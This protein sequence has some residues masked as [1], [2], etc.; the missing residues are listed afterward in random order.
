MQGARA[1]SC[2]NAAEKARTCDACAL[3]W[4]VPQIAKMIGWWPTKFIAMLVGV[5]Y[6]SIESYKALKTENKDDDSQVPA[7]CKHALIAAH[8]TRSVEPCASESG[9][10]PER[11]DDV[12]PVVVWDR[13]A[14][15][16]KCQHS[17]VG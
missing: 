1:H 16:P 9:D 3:T 15:S 13:G 8:S 12:H 4:A 17:R 14:T 7:S 2:R 10:M 6:P 11:R 5:L